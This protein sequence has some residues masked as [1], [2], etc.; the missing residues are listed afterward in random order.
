MVEHITERMRQCSRCHQSK[1]MS[2][3][4]YMP[5]IGRYQAYCKRN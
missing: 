3:F 1:Q 4:R 2:E 5:K